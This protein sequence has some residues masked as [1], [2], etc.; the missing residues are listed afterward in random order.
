MIHFLKLYFLITISMILII[1][2]S[3]LINYHLFLLAPSYE[4]YPCHP[5]LSI[6]YCLNSTPIIY[7]ILIIHSIIF[8]PIINY[9][10]NNLYFILQ[11]LI[12]ISQYFPQFILIYHFFLQSLFLIIQY[13]TLIFKFILVIH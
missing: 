12:L 6:V 5:F 9:S 11:F 8:I 3:I 1:N 7:R 10:L 4:Y 2:L 13:F